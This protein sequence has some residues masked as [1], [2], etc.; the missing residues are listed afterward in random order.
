MMDPKK[1]LRC[2]PKKAQRL[3]GDADGMRMCA[4]EVEEDGG[5]L[6]SWER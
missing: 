2:G 5:R 6:L 1:E 3:V 4:V